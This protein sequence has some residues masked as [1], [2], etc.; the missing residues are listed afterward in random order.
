M[1][2]V[3]AADH[4]FFVAELRPHRSVSERG[5]LWLVALIGLVWAVMALTFVR[6][7]AWPVIGFF[8][9]DIV[10]FG[11]L[12]WLNMRDARRRE[13]VSLS[14]SLLE[15]RRFCP[16]G[17]RREHHR[18]NPFWTRFNVARHAE[19]GITDMTLASRGQS[20]SVGAFL[21]PADKDSFAAAFQGALAQA[22][23]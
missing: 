11:W 12:V 8:G 16:R 21:N 23:R 17:L 10:L 22:R 5:A 14:R 9:L 6:M 2:D 4:P 1:P 20:V 19:I 18:F 15:V 13:E 3:P 7:G